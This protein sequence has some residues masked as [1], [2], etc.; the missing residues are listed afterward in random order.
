MDFNNITGFNTRLSEE[1]ATGNCI[2]VCFFDS[3]AAP[4]AELWLNASQIAV[5]GFK[6]STT[7][8]AYRRMNRSLQT[9][10]RKNESVFKTGIPSGIM[11]VSWGE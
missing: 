3:P 11:Q 5:L 6:L 4:H 1:I 9:P 2:I 8:L 10:E 7:Q